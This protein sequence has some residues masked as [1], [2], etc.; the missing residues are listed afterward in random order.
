MGQLVGNKDNTLNIHVN[1]TE[2]FEG[3]IRIMFE[4]TKSLEQSI[5]NHDEEREM[6]FDYLSSDLNI[7]VISCIDFT[8]SNGYFHMPNSLHRIMPGYLNDYQ[9]VITSVCEVLLNYDSDQLIQTYGFGGCP[10][11]FEDLNHPPGK[12]SHFFPLTGDWKNCAGEGIQG[13][14]DIYTQALTKVDLSG[15]TFFAPMFKEI[16]EFTKMSFEQDPDNYTV[17]LVI[18]DG[19]IHDINRTIDE[20][21][22]GSE[23]PLSIIIVGVGDA[24]FKKMNKLDSDGVILRN[25]KGQ[26]AKRDIVQFVPFNKFRNL[27][28]DKLAEEVLEEL[29]IQVCEFLK[30]QE[31]KEGLKRTDAR[32]VVD[33]NSVRNMS[34]TTHSYQTLPHNHNL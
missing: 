29:P 9:A 3:T 11:G 32:N 30:L 24:D 10:T 17:L 6:F 19:S 22:K 34:P 2:G 27:G 31:L 5:N 8:A 18:T 25:R 14:F 12:A 7:S 21:I 1:K 33:P 23:L 28:A 4:A 13:V 26:A 16:I 15:P 20:I